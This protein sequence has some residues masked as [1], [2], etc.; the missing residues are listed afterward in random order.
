MRK[1]IIRICFNL[2]T[3]NILWVSSQSD[4]HKII[5]T[6]YFNKYIKAFKIYL[7]C[8]KQCVI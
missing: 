6:K 8:I 5:Y 1:L 4:Y 3:K 2:L 7:N